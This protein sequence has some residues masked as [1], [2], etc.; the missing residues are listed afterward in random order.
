MGPLFDDPVQQYEKR[1][2]ALNALRSWKDWLQW[3]FAF[4][5]FLKDRGSFDQEWVNHL[6]DLAEKFLNYQV[7]I[8][9]LPEKTSLETVVEVF[10]RINRTGSPLGIFELLTA[11]LRNHNIQLRDLWDESIASHPR[12]AAV[13]ESKSDRYPRFILQTIALLRGRRNASAGISFSSIATPS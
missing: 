6:Q 9:E 2:V 13:S 11:R 8:I 5:Q 1:H 4:Q 3:F 7:A 10:E 12:L